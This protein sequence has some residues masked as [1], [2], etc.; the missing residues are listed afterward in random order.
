MAIFVDLKIMAMRLTIMAVAFACIA[1]ALGSCKP[2]SAGNATFC[3]TTCLKDSLKFY[4]DHPLAP[5]VYI[6]ARNC[7]ADTI[8]WSYEG[9]DADRK[10]SLA[11]YLREGLKVSKGYVKVYIRDTAFAFVLFNDCATGRGYQIKL[12]FS[13]K[14]PIGV[15]PTAITSFD[16]KFSVPDEL[17]VTTD[18]G[19]IYVED[20]ATGKQAMMTFGKQL[21]FNYDNIHQTLDSVNITS[22]RIW[23][24]VKI[25]GNWQTLEKNITLQ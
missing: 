13:K 6:T 1:L 11:E 23:T 3:D 17:M 8:V 5:Y 22:T 12:P 4:G 21:D 25:D 10:I 18:R 7:N 9:A 14:A 20:L 19:N 24:K 15:K 16:R 2:G